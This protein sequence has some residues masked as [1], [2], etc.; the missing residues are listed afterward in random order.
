[1]SQGMTADQKSQ[2]DADRRLFLFLALGILIPIAGWVAGATDADR[3]TTTDMWTDAW[4]NGLVARVF[5]VPFAISVVVNTFLWIRPPRGAS[6]PMRQ[7]VIAIAVVDL[8]GLIWVAS[9]FL[10]PS[11]QADPGLV[12]GA[13]V[14]IGSVFVCVSLADLRTLRRLEAPPQI[15]AIREAGR[16]A[17]RRRGLRLAALIGVVVVAAGIFIATVPSGT[18]SGCHA[19]GGSSVS[20][21][22]IEIDTTNCGDFALQGNDALFT[23]IDLGATYTFTTRGYTFLP[24]RPKIVTMTPDR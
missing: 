11:V 4:T 10:P 5:A 23:S 1:M 8:A 19:M 22:H 13:V 18:Y 6:G 9:L 15:R 20:G 12:A 17:R 7:I 14:A 2:C 24:W 16:G 3:S 21:G